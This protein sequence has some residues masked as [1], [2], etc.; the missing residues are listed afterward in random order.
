M[1]MIKLLRIFHYFNHRFLILLRSLILGA[2][3]ILVNLLF[4]STVLAEEANASSAQSAT[5]EIPHQHFPARPPEH[6]NLIARAPAASYCPLANELTKE[7][8]H[9]VVGNKWFSY[10]E[11]FAKEVGAFVGAQWI[12]IKVGKIMCLYQGKE[13]FDF[14]IVLEQVKSKII[15]EPIGPHW[16]SLVENHKLCKSSNVFDCQFYIKPAE[17]LGNIYEQIKYRENPEHDTDY[18][19]DY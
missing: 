16:S 1:S 12:G 6:P 18:N 19:L 17:D 4:I 15:L 14:P 10:G 13:G 11:S 2:T 5:P 8:V 9:W 3:V 7:Q